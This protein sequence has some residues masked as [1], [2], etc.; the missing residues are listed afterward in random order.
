MVAAEHSGHVDHA[1]IER[2]DAVAKDAPRLVKR[3]DGRSL[4][5]SHQARVAQ[6]VGRLRTASWSPTTML[7]QARC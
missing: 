5:G 4:V 3:R 6:D 2:L 7:G 1:T